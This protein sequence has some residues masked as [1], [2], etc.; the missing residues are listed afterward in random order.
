MSLQL[1]QPPQNKNIDTA[2]NARATHDEMYKRVNL[3][4]IML[5]CCVVLSILM[6]ILLIP[7]FVTD[8]IAHLT[9]KF[10]TKI[11]DWAKCIYGLGCLV[12]ALLV[13]LVFMVPM[14][15]LEQFG[16]I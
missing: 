7:I 16:C 6:F 8:R 4:M 1:C 9:E 11:Y 13:I 3:K 12:L 10:T 14:A 15:L 2:E 5:P